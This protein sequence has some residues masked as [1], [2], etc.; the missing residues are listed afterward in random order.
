[1]PVRSRWRPVAPNVSAFVPSAPAIATRP[2]LVVDSI[3]CQDFALLRWDM[4]AFLSLVRWAVCVYAAHRL[5]AFR[6]LVAVRPK[7]AMK[8]PDCRKSRQ[9]LREKTLS[10]IAFA[11]DATYNDVVCRIILVPSCIMQHT[12]TLYVAF[13]SLQRW[14]AAYWLRECKTRHRAVRFVCRFQSRNSSPRRA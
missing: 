3:S 12:T 7:P 8:N 6:A 5:V 11:L 2:F 10:A 9:L 4:G 1:M 14:F 13:L